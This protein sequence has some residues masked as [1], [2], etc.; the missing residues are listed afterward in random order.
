[1]AKGKMDPAEIVFITLLRRTGAQW[2]DIGL[3]FNEV[4]QKRGRILRNHHQLNNQYLSMSKPGY[5][6]WSADNV[7]KATRGAG[8]YITDDAEMDMAYL[9]PDMLDVVARFKRDEKARADKRQA[10]QNMAA[11]QPH[12]P[13]A[14]PKLPDPPPPA[15]LPSPSLTSL[16]DLAPAMAPAAAAFKP[17]GFAPP[18]P[19]KVAEQDALTTLAGMLDQR[20]GGGDTT[21]YVVIKGDTAAKL[22]ALLDRAAPGVSIDD[23][24]TQLVRV[25]MEML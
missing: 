5:D 24:A 20:P 23:L 11:S 22:R 13:P 1:M 2:P 19:V 16:K 15:K 4:A 6:G 12:D 8:K 25:G 9:T 21:C 10:R 3:A 14:L 18:P 17:A 7:L